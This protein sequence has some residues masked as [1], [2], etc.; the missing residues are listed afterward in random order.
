MSL[1]G[2]NKLSL[3][4]YFSK[5]ENSNLSLSA[6]V[7][8]FNL[9]GWSEFKSIGKYKDA[10]ILLG[11]PIN[12]TSLVN[13]QLSDPEFEEIMDDTLA[14]DI[15][16]R[17]VEKL[18][19]Q[20]QIGAPSYDEKLTL[21][22][23]QEEIENGKVQIKLFTGSRLHAKLYILSQSNTHNSLL[24]S[25]NLTYSGIKA[26][27]E[28]NT[29]LSDE[30]S[31][32]SLDWFNEKWESRFAID[33]TLQLNE[34]ISKSW[35]SED[36][37]SPFDLYLKFL[38]LLSKDARE[39]LVE[40]SIPK[41]IEKDLLEYQKNAVEISSKYL[42]KQNGIMIGDAVGFGKTLEAIGIAG[43]MQ[44][45]FGYGTLVICPPNLV[46]MWESYLENYEIFGSKVVPMSSKMKKILPL[47]RR[48][49]LVIIDESHNL[50]TGK[51]IEYD[52]IKEYIAFND[53]KVVL[54]TA[55]PYNK[56]FSDVFN[57]I[58][59]FQNPDEDIGFRPE[60]AIEQMEFSE[61]N[62]ISDGKTTTLN[63]FE[64]ALARHPN[65][66]DMQIFMSN[67]LIRRT[68]K[69]LT[70]NYSK[71]DENLNKHYFVFADGSKHYIP[72]RIPKIIPVDKNKL[73]SAQKK[74]RDTTTVDEIDGLNL[75]RYKL[76]DYLREDLNIAKIESNDLKTFIEGVLKLGNNVYSF[77]KTFLYKRLSSSEYAFIV[78]ATRRVNSDKFWVWCLENNKNI[79]TGSIDKDL[80]DDLDEENFDLNYEN[81]MSLDKVYSELVENQPNW[82]KAWVPPEYFKKLNLINDL[83]E[84]INTLGNILGLV[85][86]DNLE[87]DSKVNLLTKLLSEDLKNKKVLIFSEFADTINFVTEKLKNKLPD[88]NIECVTSG[89]NNIL[90]TASKFSPKSNGYKITDDDD[91]IDILLSTDVLSEG[92]NLQDASIVINYDLPW[93]I[94]KIIQRAG[95]VDRIGQESENVQIFTFEPDQG[96]EDVIN[97]RGRI[98]ERL[99]QNSV[100]FGSDDKF[101]GD[102]LE[103]NAIENF[104][105]GNLEVLDELESRGVE[106]DI[107]SEAHSR[108]LKAQEEYPERAELV[109]KMPNLIYSS[110]SNPADLTNVVTYF[111]SNNK[112]IFIKSTQSDTNQNL[113]FKR[114]TPRA[115]MNMFEASP[116]EKGHKIGENLI[117]TVKKAY[118]NINNSSKQDF[119][120]S[121]T[122]YRKKLYNL[123]KKNIDS[124][125][126]IDPEAKEFIQL[127]YDEPLTDYAKNYLKPYLTKPK[128]ESILFAIKQLEEMNQL[129]IKSDKNTD[130]TKVILS[131]K[132]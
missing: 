85:N 21:K 25:S 132:T 19:M 47:L 30:D 46:D 75:P 128:P 102:E 100:V 57:Q 7:G 72:K 82:I 41:I 108:W 54:L 118:L 125:V 103:S 39:G 98:R 111:Q 65:E 29:D 123:L 96:I 44:S 1:Y 13:K 94:I 70:D 69:F 16:K 48:Y 52:L 130:R 116:D 9:R 12:D 126:L 129:V 77:N 37:V 31:K 24:G 53:S 26:I 22:N 20:L 76:K 15:A 51:R 120:G 55:T 17:Y 33:I 49:H 50:R 113:E 28:L 79:P 106:V 115:A 74:L 101:F 42:Q 80:L 34:V 35:V 122:G 99:N 119:K 59:L 84:D 95:R 121:L 109:K 11:R 32:D 4:N 92:Q 124:L 18:S 66:D 86:N 104:Y 36:I 8:Y 71:F 105:T 23:L 78:S 88:L 2:D 97:L 60:N 90:E 56:D 107:V 45:Q 117:E 73:G 58:K 3:E 63:F 112:D 87:D 10:R 81:N 110:K 43:I 114:I 38:Y 64:K 67:Y 14:R 61:I 62:K 127:I 91:Y 89:S 5:N 131:L 6:L 68:R 83:K 93:T 27:G 40:Y